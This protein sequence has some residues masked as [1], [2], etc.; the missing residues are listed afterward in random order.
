MHYPIGNQFKKYILYSDPIWSFLIPSCLVWSYLIWFYLVISDLI[1]SN[2]IILFDT[3]LSDYILSHPILSYMILSNPILSYLILCYL[4]LLSHLD[5][6][7]STGSCFSGTVRLP[8]FSEWRVLRVRRSGII[9]SSLENVDGSSGWLLF[10]MVCRQPEMRLWTRSMFSMFLRP[11]R[12][13]NSKWERHKRI[14]TGH[15]DLFCLH[16]KPLYW[17][18]VSPKQHKTQ[19][20]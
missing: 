3:M 18:Q 10:I 2:P 13:A 9:V 15:W 1:L 4:T 14:L 11:G 12:S 16:H 7:T 19:T 8:S 5:L 6:L 17:D 20:T